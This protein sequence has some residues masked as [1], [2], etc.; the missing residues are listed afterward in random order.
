MFGISE[1]SRTDDHRLPGS[2]V[3]VFHS[4]LSGVLSGH[5]VR[6]YIY[7]SSMLKHVETQH[8]DLH[9]RFRL[10]QTFTL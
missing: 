2:I 3:C 1:H 7:L 9:E 6:K 5:P 4:T 10:V 8:Q